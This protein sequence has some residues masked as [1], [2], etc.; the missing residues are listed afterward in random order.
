[1]ILVAGHLLV[2]PTDRDTYLGTCRPVIELARRSPGCLDFALS[3][4]LL[5]PGRINIFE[6]WNS[7]PELQAFRGDGVGDEQGAMII[8]AEVGEWTVESDS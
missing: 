8:G 6:R 2:A 7:A 5:N 1:M 4:D 3:A